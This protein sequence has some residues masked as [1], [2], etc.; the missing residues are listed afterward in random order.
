MTHR[1][2][3]AWLDAADYLRSIGHNMAACLLEE[4]VGPPS[5]TSSE[6]FEAV[7]RREMEP[8][9]GAALLMRGDMQEEPR[10]ACAHEFIQVAG[11]DLVFCQKCLSK[12]VM[13][14]PQV[15][16][17][18]PPRCGDCLHAGHKRG[19]CAVPGCPCGPLHSDKGGSTR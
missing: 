13:P 1:N 4:R 19:Q 8:E 7:A 15:E 2:R 10:P 6:V 14:R 11:S 5:R 16:V 18:P 3:K 17:K 9:E 12:P